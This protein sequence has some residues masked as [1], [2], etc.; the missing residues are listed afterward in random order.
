MKQSFF[1][2]HVQKFKH[3]HKFK[4]LRSGD[5]LRAKFDDVVKSL[6]MHGPGVMLSMQPWPDHSKFAFGGPVLCAHITEQC[7]RRTNT[8][9]AYLKIH[10]RIC[11]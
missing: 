9:R 4:Q 8:F 7:M 3:V 1:S 2:L 11:N 10:K 5:T 6:A